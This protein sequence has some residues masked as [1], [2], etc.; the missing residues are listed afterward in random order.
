[1]ADEIAHVVEDLA[2]RQ[3][4]RLQMRGELRVLLTGESRQQTVLKGG[5]GF[6]AD[7]K[8]R[9]KHAVLVKSESSDLERWKG[10]VGELTSA[11]AG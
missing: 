9:A 3:F 2:R 11:K 6:V 1:V 7:I 4:H 10:Q 5:A 8:V